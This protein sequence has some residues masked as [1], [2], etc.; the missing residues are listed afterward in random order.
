MQINTTFELA[1]LGWQ[2][3]KLTSR[4][5]A[6]DSSVIDPVTGVD[7]RF[8]GNSPF[9]IRLD[10]R[11]DIP[12]SDWAWG[13]EMRH[14]KTDFAY[15]V[16]EF[17]LTHN[18]AT[19]GALFVE[20]KDVFGLTVKARVANLLRDENVYRRTLYNG[21]RDTGSVVQTEERALEIGT[22]FQLTV[23]GSF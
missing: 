6:E 21:P 18:P 20:H 16:Q 7:R 10:F 23:S 11:H 13:A 8:D 1:A 19:F 4:L 2:G 9:E 14:T 3:A 22:V 15:R 12:A 17:S 5:T